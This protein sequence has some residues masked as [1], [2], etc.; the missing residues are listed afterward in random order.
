MVQTIVRGFPRVNAFVLS[1]VAVDE[2]NADNPTFRS[3]RESA[4]LSL[5]AL[6][7]LRSLRPPIANFQIAD[8]T[9]KNHW[10]SSLG[11]G[12]PYGVAV[13]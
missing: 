10:L 7:V 2:E 12:W 13:Q 8:L 9:P 1:G 3:Y 6:A 4:Y 5:S 11:N